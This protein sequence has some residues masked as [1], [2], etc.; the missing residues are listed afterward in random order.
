MR[1]RGFTLLEIV[2]AIGLMGGVLTLLTTAIHQ[3]MLRVDTSRQ[4]V[5]SAQLARM[6]LQTIA[7]DLRSV[8]YVASSITIRSSGASGAPGPRSIESPPTSGILGSETEILLDRGAKWNWQKLSQNRDLETTVLPED[9]PQTIRYFYNDGKELLSADFASYGVSTSAQ[10]TTFSGLYREQRIMLSETTGFGGQGVLGANSQ[11]LEREL[12]A[13][14]VA[15]LKFAYFD[16]KTLLNSWD[17]DQNGGLPEGIEIRIKLLEEPWETA[18]ESQRYDARELRDNPENLKEYRLFV[19]LPQIRTRESE[20]GSEDPSSD[21][22]P[23][24]ANNS[25]NSAP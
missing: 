5:E 9:L 14:E 22:Q 6:L 3:Y 13:P 17:S 11:Q 2:L 12:L 15:E 8:R 23:D 18:E 4:E 1:S 16:G 24:A 25:E 10:N 20:I 21:N 19:H 7:N